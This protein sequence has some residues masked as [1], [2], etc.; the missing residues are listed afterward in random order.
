MTTWLMLF[1]SM[2]CAVHG[3]PFQQALAVAHIE[4]RNKYHAFRVGRLGKSKYFGPFGIN[5]CFTGA[6]DP[7]TNIILGVSAIARLTRKYGS[8]KAGM[9]RYNAEFTES[10]WAAIKKSLLEMGG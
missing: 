8:F 6:N 7:E 3:V 4:S 9:K 2:V 5:G 1:L 10:Y